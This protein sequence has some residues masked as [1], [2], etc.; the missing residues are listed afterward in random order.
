[1]AVRLADT[2]YTSGNPWTLAA[3]A[4]RRHHRDH[5]LRDVDPDVPADLPPESRIRCLWVAF[6]GVAVLYSSTTVYFLAEV[7]NGL[8]D[9]G[10]GPFGF[11]FKFIGEN[12]PFMVLPPLVLYSIY[13]QIDYL[14]RAPECDRKSRLNARE[15]RAAEPRISRP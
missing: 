12:V 15:D 6:T 4:R 13:L 5:R 3:R 14:T 1:M 9:I 11:W 8:D 10:Q 2:R 7:G